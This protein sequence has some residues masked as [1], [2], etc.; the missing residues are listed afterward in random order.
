MRAVENARAKQQCPA[1]VQ[2]RQARSSI[3][4]RQRFAKKVGLGF[5][6]GS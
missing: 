1:G 3:A 6:A 5:E 4:I 2:K